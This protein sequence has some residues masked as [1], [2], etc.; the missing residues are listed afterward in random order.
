MAVG[1][2]RAAVEDGCFRQPPVA[3]QPSGALQCC[4]SSGCV[5][6]HAGRVAARAYALGK[7]LRPGGGIFC[8]GE[9][10]PSAAASGCSPLQGARPTATHLRACSCGLVFVRDAN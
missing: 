10:A 9:A 6:W 8:Q 2:Q 7:A 1:V 3:I 5:A 4:S